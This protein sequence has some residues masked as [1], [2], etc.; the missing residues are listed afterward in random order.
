[1]VTVVFREYLAGNMQTVKG[2]GICSVVGHPTD[3]CLA[4]QEESI[5]QV[6][7]AGGFPGQLQ[8]KYDPY[9]STY[10]LGWR[11]HPNLSDGNP[12][13][14]PA[15]SKQEK[16]K[17]VIADKNVPN[18]DEALAE[19]RKYEQNKDLYETFRRCEV[20]IPLLDAIKQVSRY[21]KFLKEL[22]TIKRKQKLKGCEKVR[23]RENVSA[24]IQRKLPAKCKNPGM[25]TIP[26]TIGNT[27]LEKAMLDL[28]ASINVMPYS[29]YVSLKLGPLNKISVVQL[30]NRF[31]AYPKGV[32]EDVLMQVNDLVF[33][34]DFYVLDMEN[35]DQTTPILLGRP[36]LKTSKTKIDVH[37]G[38]LTM[39]FDGEIIKF[40][41][42]DAIKYPDDDNLVY[43]IDVI[44]SLAQEAFE[45]D[46]KDGLDVAISKHLEKENEELALSTN[47][48]EIVAALNDFPKLQQSGNAPHIT[49]SVSNERPLP[50]VLQAPIPDLKPLP[51]HLKYVFLGDGGTLPVIISS[52]LSAS[53][54]EKLVQVL[55]EHKTTI[56][57]SPY[58]LVFGKPCHL[59]IELEHKA[60]WA[61]KSFNM[62]MDESGEHR[63]LQLKELEEI[64][65][66]AYESA[67]I[68]KEKTKV[69]HDKIISRK[70]FKASQK[71]F[72][73]IH[74]FVCFQASCVLVGLDL[75]LLLMFFPMVQLK[76][77]V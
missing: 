4:L 75:L 12:Q 77:K 52:K 1:M 65:N 34:T 38:T 43:S 26:C 33:P 16:E 11:D 55:K 32:V 49:L 2:C 27:Q 17:N 70:E 8:R 6:N 36:F 58:W 22:C 18:D 59:P 23:V 76:F 53:Q 42:Y 67:R 29:I 40:N 25:F 60:Y 45:L 54:E 57:M 21:A 69:F 28:G 63:K 35:G 31:I 64:R 48:Q 72:Y 30:T 47:L 61:I 3:M 56:S 46:G 44:D 15:L 41:I 74:G 7:V 9:L 19:L 14:T 50:F 39:K 5:E 20:N 37:S 62:K 10:N 73:T 24:V 66:D 71:S 13:L 68:Y 51:C